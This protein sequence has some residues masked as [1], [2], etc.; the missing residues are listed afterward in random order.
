MSSDNIGVSSL[1]LRGLTLL[2]LAD[3]M[4]NGLR[5]GLVGFGLTLCDS[6]GGEDAGE[7]D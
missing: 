3:E 6:G 5:D 2:E 1:V 7:D 4:R